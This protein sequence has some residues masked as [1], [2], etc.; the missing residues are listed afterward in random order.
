MNRK[1]IMGYIITIETYSSRLVM[2]WGGG[3]VGYIPEIDAK[4][5]NLFIIEVKMSF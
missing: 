4:L 1:R 3:E 5:L 2:I